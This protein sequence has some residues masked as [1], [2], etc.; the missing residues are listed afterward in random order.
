MNK[1]SIFLLLFLSVAYSVQSSNTNYVR[2]TDRI[3]LD[4]N[5]MHQG[6]YSWKMMK[7]SDVKASADGFQVEK[8]PAMMCLRASPTSQR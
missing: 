1:L 5:E 4:S 2:T 7:V 6:E 3:W 8:S